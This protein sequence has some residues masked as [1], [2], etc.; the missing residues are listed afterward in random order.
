MKMANNPNWTPGGE[1]ALVKWI[2]NSQENELRVYYL[3]S[4][5]IIQEQ[6]LTEGGSVGW[7]HGT[8]GQPGHQFKADPG[9]ALAAV[10][11]VDGAGQIHL[12]LI[13]ASQGAICELVYDTK[14]WQSGG[15]VTKP[16]SAGAASG[17]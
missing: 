13:Y 10:A 12:R 8:L 16:K 4:D 14:G 6:C 11:W 5:D 15:V 3:D 9:S 2:G 17:D 7:F 1:L